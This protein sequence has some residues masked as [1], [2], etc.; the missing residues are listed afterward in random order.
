[1]KT[2]LAHDGCVHLKVKEGA[3][4]VNVVFQI[5]TQIEW[6]LDRSD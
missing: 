3:K 6:Y 1:M 5:G 4:M 2:E